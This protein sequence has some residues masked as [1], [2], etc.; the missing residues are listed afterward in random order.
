M[1]TKKTLI[2]DGL[3]IETGTR[4]VLNNG[5]P[6]LLRGKE[7][8]LLE[9]LARNVN[10]VVSRLTLLEYVWDYSAHTATN[11]VE[12]HMAA[13]RKKLE[14]RCGMNIIKNIYGI[15]YILKGS[16]PVPTSITSVPSNT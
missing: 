11:T 9:F 7:F 1:N 12:V 15:G 4:R 2:L 3:T 6:V 8:D 13:L 16:K 5:E 14:K 10:C